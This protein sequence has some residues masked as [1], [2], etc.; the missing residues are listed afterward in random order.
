MEAIKTSIAPW[1]TVNDGKKAVAFYAAAF[2]AVETYRLEDEG[3]FIVC[4]KINGAEIWVNEDATSNNLNN[5]NLRLILTVS[6]PEEVF[7]SAIKAG[8]KEIFPV[9]VDHGWKLGRIEDPFGLHWEIGH[10]VLS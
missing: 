9:G 5:I 2:N 8:A 6:N 3:V 1:L 10:R 7:D 4:L